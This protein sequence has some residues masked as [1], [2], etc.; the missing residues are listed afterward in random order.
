MLRWPSGTKWREWLGRYAPAEMLAILTAYAG[1]HLVQMLTGSLGAAGYGA[2][3]GENVGFYGMLL[4]RDSLA[5][6]TGMVSVIRNLFVEFGFAELL[7]S[8]IIRP[9]ATI[10]AVILLGP[11][12]GVIVGKLTADLVFYAIAITLYERRNHGGR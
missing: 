5:S 6:K 12:A 11:L 1:F 9:L 10:A 4:A 2:A 7:D 8:L 3:I